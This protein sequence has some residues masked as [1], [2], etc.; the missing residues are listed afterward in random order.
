VDA[1]REREPAQRSEGTG[2]QGTGAEGPRTGTWRLKILAVGVLVGGLVA[3]LVTKAHFAALLQMDP[4]TDGPYRPPIDVIPGFFAL[5]GTY[6][7]GVTFGAFPGETVAILVFTALATVG[8]TIWL[9]ATRRRSVWLHVA[10][11]MVLAGA[12][13]NLYD[14]FHWHKVRDFFLIYV[15]ELPRPSWKWPNFNVADALIVVGVILILAY[16]LFGR[17]PS[18]SPA[19][20]AGTRGS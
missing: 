16:E 12:L 7:K 9:V 8:L 17:R 6:N 3:D 2:G 13:G 15:G 19:P 18:S 1:V 20:S 10:L 4:T 5:E 14:R 11:G